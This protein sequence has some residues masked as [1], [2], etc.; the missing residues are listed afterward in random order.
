[1]A[2]PTHNGRLGALCPILVLFEYTVNH[3][4]NEMQSIYDQ[5][6]N[7]KS[8]VCLLAKQCTTF[9]WKD[10]ISMFSVL[11]GSAETLTRW[12]GKIYH[13]PIAC[14][15]QNI[16]VKNPTT[17]AWVTMKKHLSKKSNNACLSY[18]EKCRGCFYWDTVYFNISMLVS[19]L[20]LNLK[21][22]WR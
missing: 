18:N 19:W 14:F 7:L 9:K 12:G 4:T 3:F 13:L 20:F 5:V 11:Q 16:C 21:T 8:M 10:I 22:S 1:M 17:P 15:L 6:T 2:H